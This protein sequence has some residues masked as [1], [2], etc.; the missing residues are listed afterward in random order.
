MLLKTVSNYLIGRA[1]KRLGVELDYVRHIARAGTR[2][3]MRY[4]RIFGAIDPNTKTPVLAYHTARI[5]GAIAL[6][7]GTCVEAE[8]ALAQHAGIE[9]DVINHILL[10][11]YNELP[12]EIRSVAK[13]ADSVVGLRED[14][15]S[16]RNN[17]VK[18]FGDAGLIELSIAMNGAAYLPGI[19]RA[20]GYA[21]TCDLNLMAQ[22]STQ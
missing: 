7:C 11:R 4:N 20:M 18:A 16:A 13:L 3:L 1:E 9:D 19:K 6:D 17:V 22:H 12:S 8:M 15:A 5:R 21:T 14:N 10:S 2:L